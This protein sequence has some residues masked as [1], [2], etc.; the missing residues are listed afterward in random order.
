MD[1][2]RTPYLRWLP[3]LE[4]LVAIPS[5]G[6]DPAHAADM[7]RALAWLEPRFTDFGATTRIERSPGEQVLL[8]DLPAQ[9][10]PETAPTLLI[11]GHFDVQPAGDLSLWDSPPFNAEI[12]GEWLYG[13]GVI[14]DKG[15]LVMYLEAVRAVLARQALTVNI[16]FLID[17]AEERAGTLALD[18]MRRMTPRPDGCLIFDGPMIARGR[19]AFYVAT[20]GTLAYHLNI[21]TGARDLHSGQFGGAA[22]NAVEALITTL[23]GLRRGPDGRLPEP[24]RAGALP[25]SASVRAALPLMPEPLSYLAEQGT[26]PADAHVGADMYERLWAE[27]S[28][29]INGIAAGQPA[30]RHM[31]IPC[32]AQAAV[33]LRLAPGQ[34]VETIAATAEA[35]LR[36]AV[37]AGAELTLTRRGASDPAVLPQ[38]G[39]L[40]DAASDAFA[41]QFG[42][43]PLL[44]QAGGSL[45]LLTLL[46]DMSVVTVMTGLDLPEGNIHAPNE[47]LLLEHLPAGTAILEAL[48]SDKRF[49]R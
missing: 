44:I 2:P 8:A 30:L 25:L 33:S 22:L 23:G 34:E 40:L 41:D 16:R 36:A 49:T 18:C 4:E 20:R 6:A 46:G 17:G 9:V 37:P 21:R 47:R 48:L 1:D 11:Y 3:E 29:E 26:H 5:V 15:H 38:S 31:A 14:D 27:P 10:R 19:P 12:R 43:A 45:P 42:S 39:P 28:F 13:R 32:E 7:E 24:L 35:M